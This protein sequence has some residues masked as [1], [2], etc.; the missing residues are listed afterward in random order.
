MLRASVGCS[1]LYWMP[2][3]NVLQITL[4]PVEIEQL[5]G[6]A[7]KQGFKPATFARSILSLELAR[8]SEKGAPKNGATSRKK[9]PAKRAARKG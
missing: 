1:T 9:S 4:S 3:P 6:L 7:T 2:R 8:L 5:Q